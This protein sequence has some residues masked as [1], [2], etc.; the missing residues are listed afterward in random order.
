MTL[1]EIVTNGLCVGCGLCESLAPKA[2][3]MTLTAGGQYRPKVVD[4]LA[5]NAL[6]RIKMVC[7]GI[8][9][10]GP[11]P[12]AGR[13]MHTIWG[14]IESLSLGW[15]S[16]EQVRHRAAAGGALSAL[17]MYLLR[18]GKVDRVLHVKTSREDPTLTD[19]QV[20]ATEEEVLSGSQSR[21]GPAPVLRHV[22]ALLDAGHVMAVIAK[23][24][25]VAAIRNLANIDARVQR[26]I[27][28]CLSIFCGGVPS[29]N[30][31]RTI[32]DYHGVA[33]DDVAEFR[34]RGNG[35]PGPTHVQTKAGESFDMSYDETWFSPHVPW[36]Y[37]I[38]FRCKICPDAIG[39]LAD[40]ACPDGWVMKDGKAIHAE[41]PGQ[42]LFVARTVRGAELV[43]AAEKDGAIELHPFTIDE[44]DAM[45]RD[46][47]PRK[48]GSAARVMALRSLAQP[49]P[50]YR[51]FRKWKSLAKAGL[52]R[53]FKTF[54]D[55]RKRVRAGANKETL[56]A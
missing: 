27:P 52:W 46:H 17:G 19:A 47:H 54:L 49:V 4:T 31:A 34:F 29:N 55:T 32:V 26:Q 37:D 5:D 42:N 6:D 18:T 43:A 3:E 13:N 44:L 35:W 15:S 56:D 33:H 20:S 1:D 50:E 40:V 51:N 11:L 24:C 21:Y 7:P 45:H 8:L 14:P 22:H 28:Y 25:D 30:T 16:D 2:I 23:P 12:V 36:R 39:E 41:A 53:S 9:V 38:Q 10:N 48:L